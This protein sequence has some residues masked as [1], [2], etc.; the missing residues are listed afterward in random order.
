MQR[1]QPRAAAGAARGRGRGGALQ[2]GLE[3]HGLVDLAGA[4]GQAV[5]EALEVQQQHARQRVQHHL[6][7]CLA[8]LAVVARGVVCARR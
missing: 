2:R 4:G 5:R 6:L 8:L 3:A 1:P 7:A